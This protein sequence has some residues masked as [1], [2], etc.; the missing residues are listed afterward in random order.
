M[1]DVFSYVADLLDWIR[2]IV[3]NINTDKTM[4]IIRYYNLYKYANYSKV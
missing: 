4:H 2:N 1:F 3:Y